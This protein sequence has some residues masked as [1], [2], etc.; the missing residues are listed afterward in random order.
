MNGI[1]AIIFDADGRMITGERPSA[2]LPR[3]YGVPPEKIS[4]FF[5]NEFKECILGKRDLKEAI[6]PYL[7]VWG[8]KGSVDD[9][10]HFWFA[11]S[12][13]TEERMVQAVRALR[14]KGITC[15]LATN[16][17]KY[18]VSYMKNEMGL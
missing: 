5:D 3:E 1:K 8:W 9:M 2:R 11:E 14:G 6:A 4:A 16:Q 15:I 12:Y 17:E 10:L 7:K 18:R 13:K